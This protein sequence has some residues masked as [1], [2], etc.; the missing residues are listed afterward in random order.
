LTDD[1]A[2]RL[3]AAKA[4]L[5]KAL[6]LAPNNA[7]AHQHMG[8]VLTQTKRATQGI[9]E[10]ERSLALNPNLAQLRAEIGLAKMFDRSR[11]GS[12][13]AKVVGVQNN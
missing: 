13:G 9:A 10:F 11:R 6:L 8:T 5:T 7:V 2:A 3:A 1:R 4:T 12:R